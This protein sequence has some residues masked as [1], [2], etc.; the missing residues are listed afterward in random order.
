MGTYE[1]K[2]KKQSPRTSPEIPAEASVIPK[3]VESHVRRSQLPA[4]RVTTDRLIPSFMTPYILHIQ[5]TIGDGNCGFRSVALSVGKE[6]YEWPEIR[7]EL[8]AQL[9]KEIGHYR[10]IPQLEPSI[11][12]ILE[13]FQWSSGACYNEIY[14]MQMPMTAFIIADLYKRPCVVFTQSENVTYMPMYPPS[15]N[16]QDNKPIVLVLDF[17]KTQGYSSGHYKSVE[18]TD[19]CILPPLANVMSPSYEQWEA[20]F[21][22][23]L[24]AYSQI[25]SGTEDLNPEAE[26]S[27]TSS[28]VSYLCLLNQEE[29]PVISV[30][31]PQEEIPITLFLDAQGEAT[32]S[33]NTTYQEDT[34]VN[35][36]PDHQEEGSV[37][38]V[39]VLQ[40]DTPV[41]STLN[42][43]EETLASLISEFPVCPVSESQVN[44]IPDA[45]VEAPVSV[46]SL[47]S[48]ADTD[49]SVIA[50]TDGANDADVKPKSKL[51]RSRVRAKTLLRRLRLRT[52]IIG[53]LGKVFVKALKNAFKPASPI[54]PY[55]YE[56]PDDEDLHRF[57]RNNKCSL[58]YFIIIISGM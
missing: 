56:D 18:V 27:P 57:Y 52:A 15:E 50:H 14:H 17:P 20:L 37:N 47:L 5:N 26:I 24:Q 30:S 3:P 10:S 9:V 11:A 31:D 25:A 28:V 36:I 38:M 23:R 44:L 19:N 8:S 32:V 2:E 48:Q 34:H 1:S 6:E 53:R 13:S 4:N 7:K 54:V 40:E 33:S 39:L 51:C 45:Q 58:T 22:D 12:E 21:L 43:Q 41:S 35:L 49:A 29:S 42:S 16:E 55:Y 46:Y